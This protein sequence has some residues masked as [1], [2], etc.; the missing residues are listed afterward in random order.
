MTVVPSTLVM[1]D[2]TPLDQNDLWEPSSLFVADWSSP[3][4][5]TN[6]YTTVVHES[7]TRL[8]SRAGVATKPRKS[9]SNQSLVMSDSDVQHMKSTMRRAGEARTLTPLFCDPC[10]LIGIYDPQHMYGPSW[11][12]KNSVHS[13]LS[14]TG[15]SA[16]VLK[17]NTSRSKTYAFCSTTTVSGTTSEVTFRDPEGEAGSCYNS[18]L[19][20]MKFGSPAVT[21]KG[22]T[23]LAALPSS[24]IA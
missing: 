1:R 10:P 4:Q 2:A 17:D 7:R 23:K 14:N 16:L 24:L 19:G 22:S 12:V 18:I 11:S 13:R 6:S 5:F 9:L 20:G 8:E 21:F 15:W 3:I